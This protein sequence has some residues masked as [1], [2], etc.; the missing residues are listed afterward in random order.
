MAANMKEI[1]ARIDSVKSTSQITKAMDI[2]SSTKFKRFQALTLA[3]R[4]YSHALDETFENIV[5]S[6]QGD[7]HILFDGKSEVKK[8][9]IVIF[10]FLSLR[11]SLSIGSAIFILQVIFTL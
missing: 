2:V 6:L 11:E 5:S 1:K 8:V 4:A 7:K 10:L 3:S 9:A